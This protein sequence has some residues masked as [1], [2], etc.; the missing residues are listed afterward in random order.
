MKEKFEFADA[1][2]TKV[3]NYQTAKFLRPGKH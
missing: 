1:C 2:G 3:E